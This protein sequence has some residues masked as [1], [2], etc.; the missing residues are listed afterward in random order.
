MFDCFGIVAYFPLG[1]SEKVQYHCSVGALDNAVLA[2][3]DGQQ[4]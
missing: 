3:H 4:E 1:L 2:P